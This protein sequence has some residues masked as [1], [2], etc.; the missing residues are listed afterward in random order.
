MTRC[1]KKI[2]P[3]HSRM[4]AATRQPSRQTGPS[5]LVL[6]AF[7]L[8]LLIL[9]LWATDPPPPPAWQASV[10]AAIFIALLVAAFAYMAVHLMHLEAFHALVRDELLQVGLVAILAGILLAGLP[11]VDNVTHN[12]VCAF[13]D[14]KSCPVV[15][16]PAPADRVYA[17][18]QTASVDQ[19]VSPPVRT[20]PGTS[21]LSA[22]ALSINANQQSTLS[23][24]IQQMGG[25]SNQLGEV[26]SK[27]GFCSM[28]G[29]GFGV[30][31]CS[32]YSSL[33]GPVGQLLNAAGMGL[34]DLQAEQILLQLNASITLSLLLPLGLLLRALHFSRKVGATL[35]ALAVCLYVLF[36][37][38]LIISQS[39]ADRFMFEN[40]SD[41]GSGW[42]RLPVPDASKLTCDPFDPVERSSDPSNPA[43]LDAIDNL[44]STKT[45][46]TC[47]APDGSS[48]P[49]PYPMLTCPSDTDTILFFVLA[50]T[51]IS[52][53]LALTVT[54]AGV[55]VIG[56]A[57]GTEI[58][59]SA[60]A[61]LS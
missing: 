54:L 39:M 24:F 13:S 49:C 2:K 6:S 48:R 9:P 61:R 30:A 10:M 41:A 25:Y 38:T 8:L 45:P 56:Q 34:M 27:S 33:R 55:R 44:Q 32:A 7:I 21:P 31:G 52:T 11:Q 20:C 5:V 43:L 36:P 1:P 42:A 37:A 23:T 47:T 19:S 40:K 58:D 26:G 22:W 17:F 3:A 14:V 35:I 29:V 53:V 4:A 57:L 59:V 46:C 28:L 60:I 12:F 51:L 15:L 18:C 16:P 50:R